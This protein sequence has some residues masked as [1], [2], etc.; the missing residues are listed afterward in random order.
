MSSQD[1]VY[2][3]LCFKAASTDQNM[4]MLM[5][6]GCGAAGGVSRPAR[7]AAHRR[8]VGGRSRD[9]AANGGPG[10]RGAGASWRTM[11]YAVVSVKQYPRIIMTRCTRQYP[12]AYTTLC[13]HRA[14]LFYLPP[15]H[16]GLLHFINIVLH[17]NETIIL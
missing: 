3:P 2:K 13:V 9:E 12:R 4:D 16:D 8:G 1:R 5:F 17:N 11:Q 7:T 10:A 15:E 6:A 14:F